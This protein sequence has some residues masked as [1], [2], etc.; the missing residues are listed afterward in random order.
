MKQDAVRPLV[1]VSD[2]VCLD[3]DGWI[4]GKTS[5]P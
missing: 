5:D 1:G 2:F 4:V 3:N